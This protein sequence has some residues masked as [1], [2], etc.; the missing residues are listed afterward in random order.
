MK[1]YFFAQIFLDMAPFYAEMCTEFNQT[2]DSALME[3]LRK[4]NTDT[5]AEK[6]KKIAEAEEMEG[7]KMF[8][9]FWNFIF[10]KIFLGETDVRDAF[11]EKA[12]YLAQIGDKAE[13]L[14]VYK[15][16]TKVGLRLI[17]FYVIRFSAR[18]AVF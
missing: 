11:I 16:G 17:V 7:S 10:K 9:V 18:D 2:P 3:E 6:D 1:Y 4:K 12:N 14:A 5:L 15:K 8:E 13:A